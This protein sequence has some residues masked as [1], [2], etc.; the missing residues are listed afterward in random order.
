MIA[1]MSEDQHQGHYPLLNVVW[2][3]ELAYKYCSSELHRGS[4]AAHSSL[5]AQTLE[6]Q[7][8][9]LPQFL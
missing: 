3:S 2:D 4:A 5:L 6:L 7:T 1:F 8:M 9:E